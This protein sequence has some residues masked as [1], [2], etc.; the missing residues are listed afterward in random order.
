M[1]PL[2]GQTAPGASHAAQLW[3]ATPEH[4]NDASRLARRARERA[5]SRMLLAVAGAP[6]MPRRSL[7]HSGGTAA[8]AIAPA[9]SRAGVDMEAVVPRDVRSISQFAFSADEAR[10]LDSLAPHAATARFYLLWTLKEAFAKAL[11][12]PLLEALRDCSFT[13]R[14]GCWAGQIPTAEPWRA[15]VFTPR[16]RLTLAAVIVG[17]RDSPYGGWACREWPG[18]AVPPWPRVATLA[19]GSLREAR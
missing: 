15:T 19:G 3:L 6:D 18:P 4:G 2:R 13:H 11:A 5:A 17:A 10:E 1:Q 7:T 12:M 9:G 14:D 16:P 8:I